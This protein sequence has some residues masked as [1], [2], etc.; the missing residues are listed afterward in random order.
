MVNEWPGG[1]GCRFLPTPTRSVSED[2][3]VSEDE[4]PSSLTLRVGV[5][6]LRF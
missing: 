2:E 4:Q 1:G 6:K 5:V 3:N